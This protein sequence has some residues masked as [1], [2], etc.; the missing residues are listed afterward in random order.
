MDVTDVWNTCH[1]HLHPFEGILPEDLRHCPQCGAERAFSLRADIGLADGRWLSR[2]IVIY[3]PDCRRFDY[4]SSDGIGVT[5]LNA[6]LWSQGPVVLNLEPTTR[7]NFN[8][9][10]CVGR[11]MPESDL[12]FTNFVRALDHF[13]QLE[14]LVLVGEGEPLLHPRFFDMVT[15][16]KGRGLRVFT[17]SNGS[18][19][20]AANIRKMCESGLDYVAIS[21]DST[22]PATFASSRPNGKLDKIWAGIERLAEYKRMH[23]HEYPFI[24]VKG[25]LFRHTQTQMAAIVA[26]AAKR[27]AN[28]VE[29]FQALNPKQS[30]V[31]TYP[32]DQLANL[33]DYDEVRGTIDAGANGLCLPGSLA[34]ALTVGIP[35]SYAGRP[36]GLRNNCDEEW[37]YAMTSG[38]VTPCCQIKTPVREIWNLFDHS[39]NEIT[40]DEHYQNTR[41]NLWN[42][43]FPGHCVGCA[44]ARQQSQAPLLQ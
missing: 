20:S 24:A 2:E 29:S 12:S 7:C 8:C 23:G 43:L 42:G 38:D 22:D 18:T 17:L 19:F 3:C 21:I 1:A 44:K 5:A 30:Y 40:H 25:T 4:P 33:Q 10:Y 39:I 31:D 28:F 14:V 6:R 27:G 36:N 13:P 15:Y 32:P 11:H 41:F 37:I 34:A 26:E 16:A 9:W 35:L